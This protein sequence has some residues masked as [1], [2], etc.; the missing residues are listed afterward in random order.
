[1]FYQTG[2]NFDGRSAI[3]RSQQTHLTRALCYAMMNATNTTICLFNSGAIR[4]DDQLMGII[5]QYD[6][7]RCLPFPTSVITVRVKWF[8]TC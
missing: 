8:N 5:T 7:L 3:I 4:V 1:M 6:I 2:F